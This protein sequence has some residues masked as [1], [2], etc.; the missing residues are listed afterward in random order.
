MELIQGIGCEEELLE[1]ENDE[2]ALKVIY[3]SDES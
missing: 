2:R 3:A 1:G